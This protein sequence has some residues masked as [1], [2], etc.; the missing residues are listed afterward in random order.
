MN[1]GLSGWSW[2][3]NRDGT[4]A[5]DKP[6]SSGSGLSRI[7]HEPEKVIDPLIDL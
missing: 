7:D 5:V 2:T 3:G 4:A 6:V 1:A